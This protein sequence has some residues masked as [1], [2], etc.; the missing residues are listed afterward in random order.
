MSQQFIDDQTFTGLDFSKTA[1]QKG[2]YENCQFTDCNF[3]T[4]RLSGSTFI[5]CQVTNCDFSNATL[6]ETGFQNSLFDSCKLIGLRF[7]S[8]QSFLFSPAFKNC[9]LDFSSFYKMDLTKS[10]FQDCSL[11]DVDF[12]HANLSKLDLDKCNLT[13]AVFEQTNLLETDFR[14][15]INFNIEPTINQINKAKFAINGLRGLL[16]KYNLT[17]DL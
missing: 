2:I 13:N 3:S 5:D 10:S 12:A 16:R 4:V 8:C 14:T 1:L 9:R 11:V 15:A 6:T 7:D 17:I